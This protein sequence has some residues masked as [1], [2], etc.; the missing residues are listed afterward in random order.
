MYPCPLASMSSHPLNLFLLTSKGGW[1][2]VICSLQNV[3]ILRFNANIHLLDYMLSPS[4]SRSCL[5]MW[6]RCRGPPEG[7]PSG[8]GEGHSRWWC[9]HQNC[10]FLAP[11][12][13]LWALQ[14][15]RSFLWQQ[16]QGW[17]WSVDPCILSI[18]EA[19]CGNVVLP[20]MATT[21][22]S[23]MT[24]TEPREIKNR[25]SRMSP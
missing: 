16:S 9:R 25:E 17:I 7:R 11:H 20:N 18:V 5:Q 3:L 12:T 4:S 6:G 24:C 2:P 21:T 23:L 13:G 8:C 15:C 22:S 19:E 1:Y 10:I 14:R